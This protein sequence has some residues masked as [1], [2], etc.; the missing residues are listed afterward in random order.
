[1]QLETSSKRETM[2]V[3]LDVERE[4]AEKRWVLKENNGRA[5]LQQ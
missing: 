4:V 1:M 3:G 2:Y 5:E